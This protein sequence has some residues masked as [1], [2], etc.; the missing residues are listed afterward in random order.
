MKKQCVKGQKKI[1][2]CVS[3]RKREKNYLI[4]KNRQEIAF[5]Q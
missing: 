1:P 5:S 2:P 4:T 3:Q